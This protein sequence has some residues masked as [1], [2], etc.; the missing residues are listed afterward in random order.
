MN[1]YI[2]IKVGKRT[3]QG[4]RF[5]ESLTEALED[6]ENKSRKNK[7]EYNVLKRYGK[8]YMA[9]ANFINGKRTK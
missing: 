6:A 4:I 7:A 1:D 2:V 3:K 9:Y 8:C 5:F